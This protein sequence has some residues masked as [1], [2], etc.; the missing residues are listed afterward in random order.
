[1]PCAFYGKF[2]NKGEEFV[3]FGRYPSF[4]NLFTIWFWNQSSFFSPEQFGKVYHKSCFMKMVRK[5]IEEEMK[6]KEEK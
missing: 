5:G 6:K 3:L 1:M 2:I 4:W